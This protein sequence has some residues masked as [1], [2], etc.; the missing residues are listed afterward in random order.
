MDES[1]KERLLKLRVPEATVDIDGVGT[2]RVRGLT[3]GEAFALKKVSSGDDD[4]ER[5][6]LVRALVDPEMTED[7]VR[8]WQQNS[9]AG[10][11]EPVVA[12]VVELSGLGEG[13]DKSVVADV[14]AEPGTGVRVLPRTAT[15]DDGDWITRGDE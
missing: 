8:R 6:L 7:E 2:V 4:Y 12:K 15:R 11:L 14:P 1:L 13:A 10:E 5:K 3:R 9:P